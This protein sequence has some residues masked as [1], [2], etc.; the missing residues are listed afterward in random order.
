MCP[1][2]WSYVFS[3]WYTKT[4]GPIMIVLNIDQLDFL[5][6]HIKSWSSYSCADWSKNAETSLE[7]GS[8]A[9]AGNEDAETTSY[10]CAFS[11]TVLCDHII[12]NNQSCVITF[13]YYTTYYNCVRF[14]I[15]Q[16]H[17]WNSS[18]GW[19]LNKK[20][21]NLPCNLKGCSGKGESQKHRWRVHLFQDL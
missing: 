6:M 14:H 1:T 21:S 15:T 20:P 13:I 17:G 3:W 11:R 7:N 4:K 10:C 5:T 2:T 9:F 8:P 12:K 19:G 16:V 18:S